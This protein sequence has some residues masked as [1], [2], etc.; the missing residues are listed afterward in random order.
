SLAFSFL[1]ARFQTWM[2]PPLT[3]AATHLLSDEIATA[4]TS[5]PHAKWASSLPVVTSQART[6]FPPWLPETSLALSGDNAIDVMTFWGPWMT[7]CRAPLAASQKTTCPS[8]TTTSCLPSAVYASIRIGHHV[9]QACWPR[10]DTSSAM[11]PDAARSS[12]DSRC[13]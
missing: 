13:G 4:S 2:T 1:S 10:T 12:A 5:A 9:C 3:E 6:D 11:L 8:A 7:A